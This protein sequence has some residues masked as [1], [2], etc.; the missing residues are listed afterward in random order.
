MHTFFVNTAERLLD[1][2]NGNVE[3]Y[4][5]T[6]LQFANKL[7]FYNTGWDDL[8]ACAR[9]ICEVI[10]K[11]QAVD[12]LFNVI[13]YID[14]HDIRFDGVTIENLYLMKVNESFASVLYHGGKKAQNIQVIFGEYFDRE[15]QFI[16]DRLDGAIL[17]EAMSFPGL[18]A[19]EK[20][21]EVMAEKA[22]A[23]NWDGDAVKQCLSSEFA[24]LRHRKSDEPADEIKLVDSH[25]GIDTTFYQG[26]VKSFI[27]Q[28]ASKVVEVDDQDLDL[29]KELA[30]FF[31]VHGDR[32]R[33]SYTENE[34]ASISLSVKNSDEHQ[35][36]RSAYQLYLYV[37]HCAVKGTVGVEIPQIDWREFAQIVKSRQWVFRKEFEQVQGIESEFYFLNTSAIGGEDVNSMNPIQLFTINHDVPQLKQ[38]EKKLPLFLPGKRLFKERAELLTDLTQ[39]N[40]KNEN[41][42]KDF[43]IQAREKF[44]EG[45]G[46]VTQNWQARFCEKKGGTKFIDSNELTR[47]R[48]ERFMADTQAMIAG[49][50]DLRTERISFREQIIQTQARTDYWFDCIK[51]KWWFILVFIVASFVFFAIPYLWLQYRQLQY[52]DRGLLGFFTTMG[53]IALAFWISYF[54]FRFVYKLAIK[55]DLRDLTS[56]FNKA[57]HNKEKNALEYKWRLTQYYP[58]SVVLRSYFKEVLQHIQNETEFQ[59]LKAYHEGYLMG[60]LNYIDELVYELDIGRLNGQVGKSNNSEFGYMLDNNRIRISA[61]EL[62]DLYYL[63]NTDSISQVFAKGGRI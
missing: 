14:L 57:Q 42:L 40:E 60:M 46:S 25:I 50:A 56:A 43:I 45:K 19:V 44:I 36:S 4:F 49:Q 39:R 34:L 33:R 58:R 35:A 21:I 12:P 30:I 55:K 24:E 10:D 3:K 22:H 53:V 17:W 54:Y 47:T 15:A 29:K 7:M 8:S 16:E 13:I 41:L 62:V 63:L 48:A 23:G 28:L 59:H 5:Y 6:N 11:D 31:E 37:Y 2:A 32:L 38:I 1:A 9:Q 18:D 20:M 27:E 26:V 52:S 61:P 51:W